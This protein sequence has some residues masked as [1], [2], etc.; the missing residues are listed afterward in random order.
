MTRRTVDFHGHLETLRAGPIYRLEALT[1]L[2]DMALHTG[3]HIQ[4]R[5]RSQGH[6]LS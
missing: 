5:A 2:I 6:A 1:Q 4:H 3:S